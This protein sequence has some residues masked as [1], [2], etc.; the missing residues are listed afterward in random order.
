MSDTVLKQITA[1]ASMDIATLKATWRDLYKTEPPKFNRANIER[2]LAYRI[3]EIAYGGL[4]AE[5]KAQIT[6][7]RRQME[8]GTRQKDNLGPPPS[9]VLVREYQ[10]IEHRVTVLDGGFEYQGRRYSSLSVIARAITGT[11]W[12]GPLFFGLKR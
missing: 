3:Q 2:R 10:G 9:T 4:P 6:Q 5:I 8:A 1:L 11:Q 7:M 12:S